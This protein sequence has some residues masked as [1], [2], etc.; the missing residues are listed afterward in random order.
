MLKSHS[1]IQ[2]VVVSTFELNKPTYRAEGG[3]RW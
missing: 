2:E 1:Y 3:E